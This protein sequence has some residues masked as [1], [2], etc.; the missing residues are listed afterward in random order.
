[1]T[2]ANNKHKIQK[3]GILHKELN[4]SRSKTLITTNA[5][6]NKGNKNIIPRT[7]IIIIESGET[8]STKSIRLEIR[9]IKNQE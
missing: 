3:I 8:G 7:T 6:Y 4:L 1:M 2:P 9:A 5:Q